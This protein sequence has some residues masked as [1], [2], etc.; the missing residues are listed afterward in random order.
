VVVAM[1]SAGAAYSSLGGPVPAPLPDDPEPDRVTVLENQIRAAEAR[2][3]DLEASADEDFQDHE[4]R[5]KALEA[6]A[7]KLRAL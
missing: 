2:L 5:I 6:L 7:A 3:H 1:L 4:A